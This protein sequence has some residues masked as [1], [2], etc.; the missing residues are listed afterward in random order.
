[1][2]IQCPLFDPWAIH[3]LLLIRVTLLAL[4]S[5]LV[6]SWRTFYQPFTFSLWSDNDRFF[7]TVIIIVF[8]LHVRLSDK[9]VQE[10]PVRELVRKYIRCSSRLTIAQVKKFLKVKLNLTTA[11]QVSKGISFVGSHLTQTCSRIQLW[12]QGYDQYQKS[13]Y[14]ELQI[15]SYLLI[16]SG[17]SSFTLLLFLVLLLSVCVSA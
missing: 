1:M 7:L 14:C 4:I 8:L 16:Q 3:C 10:Q 9:S 11:D 13:V 12:H 17:T 15:I 6:Q 2:C 5:A